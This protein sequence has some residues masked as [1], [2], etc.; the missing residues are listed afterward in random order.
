[1]EED[2]S[3]TQ[4][5]LALTLEVTQQAVSHRLKSLGMV[6]KQGNWVPYE[7]E[8]KPRYIERRLC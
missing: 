8:L 2:S 7:Y 3:Q 4:K 6:H 1:M 5:E